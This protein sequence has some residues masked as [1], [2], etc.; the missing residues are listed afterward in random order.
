MKVGHGLKIG[1]KFSLVLTVLVASVLVVGW[2]GVTGQ[3][4][5]GDAAND[6]YNDNV[7]DA[8]RTAQVERQISQAGW[9][10]LRMI[11][12]RR[13]EQLADLRADLFGQVIPEVD[14]GVAQIGGRVTT[15]EEVQLSEQLST[16]WKK[17]T[18]LV[19]GPQFQ[20]LARGAGQQPTIQKSTIQ[21]LSQRVVDAARSVESTISAIQS[22]QAVEASAALSRVKA[23]TTRT[24]RNVLFLVAIALLVGVGSVVLLI[25]NVVPRVRRYSDFAAQVAAGELSGRLNPHGGDELS[26]LGRTLDV[27]VERRVTDRHYDR[28][29]VELHEAMQVTANEEEAHLLLKKHL[30]R[31]VNGSTA[32]VLNRNNSANHLQPTTPLPQASPLA[33]RL[34]N[35]PPRACLAVRLGR[36][37]DSSPASQ[38]LLSC[39]VCGDL[40]GTAR[41]QPLLVSGEVIGSVLVQ[42]AEQTEQDRRCISES[43]VLAAPVLANLR[44]LAL[45]EHRAL[46]DAL[47]GLPNR[48]AC[49]D[50]LR[51][52]IAQASRSLDPLGVVLLDLDH[53]KQIKDVYGHD[54]GDEVLAAV[55]ASLLSSTRSSDF[56][57]RFG[58]EEFLL[59]L[60]NTG[61]EG[62]LVIAE[63][64]RAAIAAINIAGI[65]RRISASLGVAVMPDHAADAAALLRQA[66]RALYSAKADGRDRTT[67]VQTDKHHPHTP[68]HTAAD[69]AA[70]AAADADA[71]ADAQTAGITRTPRNIRRLPNDN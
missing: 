8:Q 15:G 13:P 26:E 69:N 53:F 65:D 5:A 10:A 44:N 57:G 43:V 27:L 28:A 71:D 24:L 70:D 67:V 4:G 64:V 1:T 48:R 3:R 38:A 39:V 34:S 49:H 45:A 47:T 25:R 12:E 33:E 63:H 68:S 19:S 17:F 35:A 59:L 52:M 50:T 16:Q 9:L 42:Q 21:R 66:D 22:A 46:S 23:E 30:E 51:R 6:I 37:H 36:A 32:V 62:A 40:D 55:G 2:L 41:C 7:L 54:R 20:L 29:Q 60:A 31:N 58:G 11:T 56:A 61:V 18:A 14:Q